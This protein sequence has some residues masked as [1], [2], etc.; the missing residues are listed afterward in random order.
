VSLTI[1]EICFGQSKISYFNLQTSTQENVA[2]LHIPVNYWQIAAFVQIVQAFIYHME[3]PKMVIE[4]GGFIYLEK[5]S[6]VHVFFLLQH[7]LCS[8]K[9]YLYTRSPIQGFSS[10]IFTL[11]EKNGL[12]IHI[13]ISTNITECFFFFKFY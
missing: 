1:A 12:I 5:F 9:H 11:I 3:M 6:F 4:H 13:S 10:T 7:T 8:F 2:S